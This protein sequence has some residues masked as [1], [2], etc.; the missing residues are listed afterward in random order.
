MFN[1]GARYWIQ[2]YK[3]LEANSLVPV[4]DIEF[5]RSI[6]GCIQSNRLLSAAQCKRMKKII[7]TAEDAGYI[8][9]EK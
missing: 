5:V 7:D 8:M 1:L 3:D 9:R 4:G 6:A 2:F